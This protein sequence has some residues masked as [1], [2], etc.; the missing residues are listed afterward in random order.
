MTAAEDAD[1]LRRA[2]SELMLAI[3]WAALRDAVKIRR[4]WRRLS[5]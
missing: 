1:E 4:A 5:S 2:W 3:K